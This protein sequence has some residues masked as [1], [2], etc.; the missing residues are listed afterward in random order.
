MLAEGGDVTEEEM[1]QISIPTLV[2]WGADDKVF[3]PDN[4]TRLRGD[5][6]GAEVRLI[7]SAG[8]LPQIEKTDEFLETVLPFLQTVRTER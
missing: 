2:V 7:E 8:H 1:R 4:A 6:A 5:I 3:S